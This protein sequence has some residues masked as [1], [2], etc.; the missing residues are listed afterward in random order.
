MTVS[1]KLLAMVYVEITTINV[2]GAGPI[3][4]FLV[5]SWGVFQSR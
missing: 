2:N 5:Q 1:L 4:H 3:S